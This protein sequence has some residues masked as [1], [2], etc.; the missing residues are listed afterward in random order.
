MFLIVS[1][2]ASDAEAEIINLVPFSANF[3]GL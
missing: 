2:S 3:K 1:C